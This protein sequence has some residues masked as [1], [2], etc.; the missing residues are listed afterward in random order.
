VL[1]QIHQVDAYYKEHEEALKSVEREIE[2][3]KEN[4]FKHSQELFK[5]R[6]EEANLVADVHLY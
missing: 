2:V 3:M 4:M 1:G 6:K 5:L